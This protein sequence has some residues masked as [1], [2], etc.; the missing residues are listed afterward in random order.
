MPFNVLPDLWAIE[1]SQSQ[2]A[3]NRDKLSTVVTNNLEHFFDAQSN[4]YV[5]VAVARNGE[6]ADQLIRLLDSR[7]DRSKPFDLEHVRMIITTLKDINALNFYDT[8][9]LDDL[10]D[11][12]P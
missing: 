9:D 11:D 8:L 3:F 4:D 10:D 7:E 1:Y 12:E 6:E 2:G 5:I